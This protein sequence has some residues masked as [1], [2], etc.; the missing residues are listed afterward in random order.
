M[1]TLI[2]CPFHSRVTAVAPKDPGQSTRC[3]GD[4]LHLNTRTPLTQPSPSGLTLPLFRHCVGTYP[5]TSSRATCQGTIGQS[6]QLAE[7]L[8]TDSCIKSGISVHER[9]YN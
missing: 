3:A 8:W 5:E 7:P 6:S 1:L 4:R 2:R 9:N